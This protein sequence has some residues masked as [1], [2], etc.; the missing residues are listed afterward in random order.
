MK[1]EEKIKSFENVKIVFKLVRKVENNP[2]L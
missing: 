2:A 1:I